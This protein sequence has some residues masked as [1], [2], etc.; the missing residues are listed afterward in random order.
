DNITVS[1]ELL[2]P[3]SVQNVTYLPSD[4]SVLVTWTPIAVADGDVTYNVYQ[5]NANATD[6]KLLTAQPIKEASYRAEN[7][8]DGQPYRFA[9]TAVVNGVESP[10]HFPEP[11]STNQNGRR[12]IGVAV[13][14]P[15]VLLGLQMY[16]VGTA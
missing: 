12:L 2:S 13:P 3:R 8:T 10:L 5:I 6:K 7:L 16:Y 4:K 14:N 1:N 15:P 9:V 11:N